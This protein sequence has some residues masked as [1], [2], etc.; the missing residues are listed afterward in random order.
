MLKP[1]NGEFEDIVIR[2][3]EDEE[4]LI[5]AEVIGKC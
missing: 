5:V 2:D 4:F 1:L 3:A